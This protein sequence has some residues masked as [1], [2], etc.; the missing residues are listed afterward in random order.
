MNEMP[1]IPFASASPLT[2]RTE[3]KQTAALKRI[4]ARKKTSTGKPVVASAPST[5]YEL[6]SVAGGKLV[7]PAGVVSADPVNAYGGEK[8]PKYA[9]FEGGVDDGAEVGNSPDAFGEGGRTGA[10]GFSAGFSPFESE[11]F[12]GYRLGNMEQPGGDWG[13]KR[14]GN[15]A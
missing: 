13:C 1:A 8:S 3:A 14:C 10:E 15:G 11:R 6:A 9:I 5:Y 12:A 7:E 2:A 4:A